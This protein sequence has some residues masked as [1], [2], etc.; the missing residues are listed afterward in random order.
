ME[1]D[2]TGSQLFLLS[3]IRE[4]APFGRGEVAS[5]VP[6]EYWLLP[7]HCGPG[8]AYFW[9]SGLPLEFGEMEFP[10]DLTVVCCRL[11]GALRRQRLGRAQ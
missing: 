2:T 4:I 1:I 3:V 5:Q 10:L 6:E 8:Q 11:K 9:V 7:N